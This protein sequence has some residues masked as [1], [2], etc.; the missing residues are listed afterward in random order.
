[1]AAGNP[2][3][4]MNAVLISLGAN[5]PGSWGTPIE[6]LRRAVAELRALP[7]T[8]ESASAL[9][10]TEPLGGRWQA[11]YLNAVILAKA[12]VSPAMLL[13]RLKQLERR[14][15]R[16]LGVHWGPRPLDL[17]IIDYHG[18]RYGW[19][20]SRRHRGRLILPHP[21]AHRR[22][23][24]LVPLLD[25]APAW[26]HPVLGVAARTLLAELGPQR[27]GV[28]RVLDSSWYLCEYAGS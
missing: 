8:I 25:V 22:A 13:R 10:E 14:A 16:R 11:H 17:D 6:T 27:R 20:Y 7:L 19:P 15:G 4:T 28:R 1:M 3:T 23:F 5:L 18:S 26:R 12:K 24:V 9:Y 2:G 21:E